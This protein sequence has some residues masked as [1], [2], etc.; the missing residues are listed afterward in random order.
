[1]AP[2]ILIFAGA[3]ASNSLEWNPSEL[4]DH[5]LEPLARFAGVHRLPPPPATYDPADEAIASDTAVWRSIPLE[6][7][8]L[9]TGFSQV[10]EFAGTYQADPNFFS[11]LTATSTGQTAETQSSEASQSLLDEFY[12][13]SWA[14]HGDLPSSQLPSAVSSVEESSFESTYDDSIDRSTQGESRLGADRTLGMGGAH[15]SDLEDLPSALYL[16]SI[17]PQTMTVNLIVG[18]I[19]VAEPRVVKT[20]WGSEQ[21]LVELLVGDETKSGFS[22]T[23][24][25]SSKSNGAGS[26]AADIL[27]KSLRR[28]D[29]VLLR[30]VA[31][32]HFK[33]KV[34]GHSLRK[35]T[36]RID[37]LYR[38]KLEANDVGGFYS[39][40]DL[41]RK[42][43]HPQLLKT[44][45]VR[46]WVLKFVGTGGGNVQLG[47][48]K[49]NERAVRSW[50]MPPEDSQ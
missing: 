1:M 45:Q 28:Q 40:K 13:H 42:G 30:N 43:N 10:H 49:A 44:K 22:I 38:R 14:I 24:W 34:H 37:L 6:R 23:F 15:L 20:R 16:K 48:R 4:L 33:E 25:L 41:S 29:I 8:R 27:L 31:L 36:T 35:A 46:E 17:E 7:T 9:P 47:K 19:S 3:P 21:S 18:I 2:K 11:L 5:F 50:E 26:S 12:Q 39:A 32:S